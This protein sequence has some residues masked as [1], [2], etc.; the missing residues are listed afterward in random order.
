MSG[1]I[2]P[3]DRKDP[4]PW[5]TDPAKVDQ[6]DAIIVAKGDR[7]GHGQQALRPRRA[8]RRR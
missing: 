4:G 5:R 2:S 7:V 8:G 3:F 1:S 6:W